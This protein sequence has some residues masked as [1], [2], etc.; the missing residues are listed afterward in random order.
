MTREFFT[1]AEAAAVLGYHPQTMWR[2]IRRGDIPGAQHH[3]RSIRIPAVALRQSYAA[4]MRVLDD[5]GARAY[6]SSPAISG[7]H[8]PDAS[9]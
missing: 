4:R 6:R 2:K 5:A 7:T 9:S 3:G 8:A 1:V